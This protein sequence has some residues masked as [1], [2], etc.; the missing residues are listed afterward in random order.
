MSTFS[1][2]TLQFQPMGFNKLHGFSP[3]YNKNISSCNGSTQCPMTLVPPAVT[4]DFQQPE[5]NS[6]R[7][8]QYAQGMI[9][10][11]LPVTLPYLASPLLSLPSAQPTDFINLYLQSKDTCQYRLSN[12]KVCGQMMT[13]QNEPSCHWMAM[14]TMDE[15]MQIESGKLNISEATIITMPQRLAMAKEYR[16]YCPYE[17]GCWLHQCWLVQ[18]PGVMAHLRV[19]A[20]RLNLIVSLKD[21][22]AWCNVNMALFNE[23]ILSQICHHITNRRFGGFTRPTSR[24][25]MPGIVTM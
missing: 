9:Q 3:N 1:V 8:Y 7:I 5:D 19:C 18:P 15:V 23:K 25:I 10:D 6:W 22:K 12:S 14:H 24:I 17:L 21:A 11:M 2:R 4:N 13:I 20:N 16:V